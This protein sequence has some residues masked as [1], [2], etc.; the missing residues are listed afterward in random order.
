MNKLFGPLTLITMARSSKLKTFKTHWKSKTIS[1]SIS[2][3]NISSS[4][5]ENLQSLLEEL[6]IELEDDILCARVEMKRRIFWCGKVKMER[7]R[8]WYAKVK[9]ERRRLGCA[10]V[11]WKEDKNFGVLKR[12]MKRRLCLKNY[13]L[14]SPHE[15]IWFKIFF[16]IYPN[17]KSTPLGL[18][19]YLPMTFTILNEIFSTFLFYLTPKVNTKT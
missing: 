1:W 11:K 2:W 8:N 14:Y 15:P 17:P 9:I 4:F 3:N 13:F 16:H 6:W 19:F 7:G 12:K 5:E 18:I 10:K